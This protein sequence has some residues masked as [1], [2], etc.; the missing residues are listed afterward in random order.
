[1]NAHYVNFPVGSRVRL[2]ESVKHTSCRRCDAH[3]CA[4]TAE[5]SR[6]IYPDVG[7]L[8]LS[9]RLGGFLYWNVDDVE[10]AP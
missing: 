7:G 2:R 10:A 1:M 8:V 3:R 9:D 6:Y 5:I 4:C